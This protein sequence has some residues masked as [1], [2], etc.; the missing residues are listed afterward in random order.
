MYTASHDRLQA[1]DTVHQSRNSEAL[2][3]STMLASR[4]RGRQGPRRRP[5]PCQAPGPGPVVGLLVRALT[6]P[7]L[8]LEEFS[9]DIHELPVALP[10][11]VFAGCAPRLRELHLTN[12]IFSWATLPTVDA[13][14]SLSVI[15]YR[16]RG[17][18]PP[19]PP[20][21]AGYD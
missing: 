13:L 5:L 21:P 17:H 18:P 14:T 15:F 8:L 11:H 20:P 16:N 4:A 6:L 7:A 19:P 12:C 3:Q 9:L 2:H 10:P 1:T